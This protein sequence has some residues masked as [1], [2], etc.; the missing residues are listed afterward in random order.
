MT[1]L[2]L[3]TPTTP[4]DQYN[5]SRHTAAVNIHTYFDIL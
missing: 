5:H 4:N 1:Y 2:T 3:D